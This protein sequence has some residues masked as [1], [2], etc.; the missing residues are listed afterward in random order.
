MALPLGNDTIDQLFLK[1]RS[2]NAWLPEPVS[3]AQIHRLYELTRQGPTA[4]NC[5]P[6][7][8]VFIRTPEGKERIKPA[9]MP[10]NVAKALS[11]PV[12]AIVA[13]DAQW[14]DSLP[15]LFPMDVAGMFRTN[16]SLAHTTA[17][18]NGSFQGAYL[19][20]AARALGLDCGP[21][22]GFNNEALD[23]AFFTDGQWKSNFICAIGHGDPS[24]LRPVG[25]RLDFDAACQLA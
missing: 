25:P 22:S 21:M 4:F 11:A 12:L 8:F 2:Q 16:E 19:M 17:M 5:C 3:D 20:L 23:K 6:A 1:A 13:Y 9:L 7:R 14:F 24:A 15:K 10:N 18:R